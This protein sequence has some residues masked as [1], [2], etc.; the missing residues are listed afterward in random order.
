M[1]M[2]NIACDHA[3]MI[4]K[5]ANRGKEAESAMECL[6]RAV[7]AGFNNVA[8][9]KRDTDLDALRDREDFKQLLAKLEAGKAKEKKK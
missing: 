5:S 1:T 4:P 7:A 2:Y 9:M 8:Q 6:K 3:V